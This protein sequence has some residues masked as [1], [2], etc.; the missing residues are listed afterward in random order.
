MTYSPDPWRC[1]IYLRYS[2]DSSGQLLAQGRNEQ[3]GPTITNPE[4]VE[5]KLRAAQLAILNPSVPTQQF[6]GVYDD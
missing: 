6:L 1:D 2:Y 3:F 5:M 4:D